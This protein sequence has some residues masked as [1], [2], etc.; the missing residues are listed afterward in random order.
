MGRRLADL[1]GLQ[2]ASSSVQL[3]QVS[4]GFHVDLA[5]KDKSCLGLAFLVQEEPD[6][7]GT[8]RNLQSLQVLPAMATQPSVEGRSVLKDFQPRC[9][10]QQE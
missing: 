5:D 7:T 1:Q 3:P 4:L 10:S 8:A 2:F 6:H 9:L